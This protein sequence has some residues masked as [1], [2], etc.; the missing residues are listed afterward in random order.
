MTALFDSVGTAAGLQTTSTPQSL[1]AP[2]L[3]LT[4]SVTVRVQV[5]V[6]VVASPVSGD[7]GATVP[8][9]EGTCDAWQVAGPPRSEKVARMSSPEQV[10]EGAPGSASSSVAD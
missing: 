4:R 2:L 3:P 7:T 6:V 8:L 5:P 1:S 9:S 10:T